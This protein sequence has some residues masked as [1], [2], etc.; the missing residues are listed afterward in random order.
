MVTRVWVEV[1][2]QQHTSP[3]N[4][5]GVL[6]SVGRDKG[7]TLSLCSTHPDVVLLSL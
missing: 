5:L 7:V 1:G 2:T 3:T 4:T 6:G